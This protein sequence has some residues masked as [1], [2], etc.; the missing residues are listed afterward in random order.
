MDK[1]QLLFEIEKNIKE[2]KAIEEKKSMIM[3]AIYEKSI[4]QIKTQKFK[5]VEDYFKSQVNYYEQDELEYKEKIEQNIKEYKA[6]VEQLIEAYNY[7]YINT[8]N[9]M[10]KAINNQV[11]AMGNT[12]T[13]WNKKDPRFN[14]KIMAVLQKKIN[15]SVIVEE[16]KARLNWCIE[17][18]QID[19]NNIFT[20]NFYQMQVYKGGFF[21]KLK[22]KISNIING[23]NKLREVIEKYEIENLRQIS[24]NNKLKVIEIFA[25]ASG[26]IK[27]I[28]NVEK[29]ISTQ[30]EQAMQNA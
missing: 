22:R 15:Y 24:N 3:L 19:M 18:V 2:F 14:N 17:N 9:N 28:Q 27:Q 13:L 29:Q 1:E 21:E 25:I 16:C 10:Q 4:N 30:Y 23:K 6:Q 7:L 26:V 5:E 11:I 12:V 8:Y 20:N